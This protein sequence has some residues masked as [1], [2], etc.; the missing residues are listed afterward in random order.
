MSTL[1]PG[2]PKVV[3]RVTTGFGVAEFV[4]AQLFVVPGPPV[5]APPL[6]G[7]FIST[8]PGLV[9]IGT[10][11]EFTLGGLWYAATLRYVVMYPLYAAVSTIQVAAES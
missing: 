9:S 3:P 11:F 5:P 2:A 1:A 7:S 10:P 4:A 8:V 6:A